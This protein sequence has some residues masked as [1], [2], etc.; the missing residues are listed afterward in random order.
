MRT[1]ILVLCVITGALFLFFALGTKDNNTRRT[2][3]VITGYALI[4][5]ALAGTLLPAGG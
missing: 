3:Y 5:L 1:F 4:A 2:T